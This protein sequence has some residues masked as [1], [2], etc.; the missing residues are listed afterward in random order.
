M[1]RAGVVQPSRR[2]PSQGVAINSKL[3]EF[4]SKLAEFDSK[5]AE[6]EFENA[7]K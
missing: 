6:F 5:L 3:A 4:D 2:R 7:R 1:P